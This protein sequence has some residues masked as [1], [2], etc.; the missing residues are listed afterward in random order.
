MTDWIA[1]WREL[2]TLKSSPE[3]QSQNKGDHWLERAGQFNTA[4][5]RRWENPDSS[6]EFVISL[7]KPGDTLLDIGAGTGAWETLLAPRLKSITALEPSPSM[8]SI[9]QQNL[10]EAGIENVDIIPGSWPEE[11]MHP[12][13]FSLC[14]HSM[15]GCADFVVFINKMMA[16]TRKTCILIIRQPLPGS[17]MTLAARKVFGH[18]HDS[19]N[20]EVAYNA[21]LQMGIHADVIMENSGSWEPW[22][23][24][25]F[26]QALITLKEKL[27]LFSPSRFD[28]DLSALLRENLVEEGG[29]LIWPAGVRSVLIHWNVTNRLFH[30]FQ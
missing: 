11:N 6:R 16:V 28:N 4:V 13:T 25:D 17:L 12:H 10:Q 22:T 19:P 3:K 7:L 29:R 8:R 30:D 26:E 15:Y 9:L 21:L 2:V 14:A 1:L 18:P 20:F 24:S 27:G 23:S 5:K